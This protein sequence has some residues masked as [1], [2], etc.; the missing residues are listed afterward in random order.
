MSCAAKV[1]KENVAIEDLGLKDNAQPGGNTT[2]LFSSSLTPDQNKLECFPVA[3]FYSKFYTLQVKTRHPLR[4]VSSSGRLWT[5]SQ[6]LA[7][8]GELA[9]DKRSSLNCPTV[10]DETKERA[11]YI[12]DASQAGSH[13]GPNVIK[14]FTPVI[15]K[16][17]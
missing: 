11:F 4:T 15:Y 16:F 9:W 17:L 10:S 8:L 6:I 2:T 1:I 5:Y 13:P 7:Y 14:L 3:N 12:T